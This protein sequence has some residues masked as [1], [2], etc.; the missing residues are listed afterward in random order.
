MAN[1]SGLYTTDLI[2]QEKASRFAELLNLTWFKSRKG[3]I[4]KFKKRNNLKSYLV[5]G[6]IASIEQSDIKKNQ[7]ILRDKLK[8]FAR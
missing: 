2:L 1:E 3:W 4:A 7:E 6:E 5:S 8:K